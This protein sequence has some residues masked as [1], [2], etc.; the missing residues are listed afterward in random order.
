MSLLKIG[1]PQ[2]LPV[3]LSAR[4]EWGEPARLRCGVTHITHKRGRRTL[5]FQAVAAGADPRVLAGP[6]RRDCGSPGRA[7][8]PARRPVPAP[9]AQGG[10]GPVLGWPDWLLTLS[11]F[12]LYGTPLLSGIYWTGL[13]AMVAVVVVGFGAATLLMERRELSR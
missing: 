4:E 2:A 6:A 9:A 5:P 8:G 12:Q 11:V 1:F 3:T 13:W 10:L 7:G